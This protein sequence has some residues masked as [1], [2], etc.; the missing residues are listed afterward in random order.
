MMGI[1]VCI[2]VRISARFQRS[3]RA[4]IGIPSREHRLNFASLPEIPFRYPSNFL[5]V[6]RFLSSLK[7]HCIDEQQFAGERII[8]FMSF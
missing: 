3:N 4:F 8:F 6:D 2:Y 5:A 7:R 1:Y